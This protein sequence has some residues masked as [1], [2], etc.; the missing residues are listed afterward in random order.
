MKFE[1]FFTLDGCR[2]YDGIK[3]K[4]TSSEIKNPDGSLSFKMTDVVPGSIYSQLDISDGDI[5]K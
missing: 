1:R 3:F 5:I 2:D 4:T